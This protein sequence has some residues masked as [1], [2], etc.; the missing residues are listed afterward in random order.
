M[1]PQVQLASAPARRGAHSVEYE[2]ISFL[3]VRALLREKTF[4]ALGFQECSVFPPAEDPQ[5]ALLR[6][7]MKYGNGVHSFHPAFRF[8]LRERKLAGC[9]VKKKAVAIMRISRLDY[10]VRILQGLSLRRLVYDSA[11]S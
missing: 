4:I 2:N 5:S 11:N 7:L 9:C 8:A 1:L 6:Y 10:R 3:C